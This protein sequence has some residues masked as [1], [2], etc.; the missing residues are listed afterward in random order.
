MTN[1]TRTS[2]L[3]ILALVAMAAGLAM[4]CWAQTS[5]TSGA[6]EGL[7]RDPNGAVV[8]TANVTLVNASL[9]VKRTTTTAADGTYIFP[10]V[11]PASGYEVD[12]E[13]PIGCGPAAV[14][15][16][17]GY[18]LRQLN[19]MMRPKNIPVVAPFAATKAPRRVKGKLARSPQP[20]AS[21][22]PRCSKIPRR[23]GKRAGVP[24]VCRNTTF[25]PGRK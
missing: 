3:H 8:P 14:E 24:P 23:Y 4:P 12:V 6:V 21:R 20:H 15:G 16:D 13:H 22:R 7:V 19:E 11:E 10:L 17:Q 2:F 9:G 5:A 18:E 1:S 25:S